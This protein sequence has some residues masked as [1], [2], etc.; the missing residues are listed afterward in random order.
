MAGIECG[1]CGRA[2][3]P[4]DQWCGLCFAPAPDVR[5][6]APLQTHRGD[7]PPPVERVT[8]RQSRWAGSSISF[9]P[10]GRILLTL[11]LAAITALLVWSG[12][13]VGLGFWVVVAVPWA[14]RDIWRAVRVRR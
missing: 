11:V 13:L 12:S 10:V 8:Y 2:L 6:S 4:A 3:A 7:D 14:L 1:Q 5:F 9:G